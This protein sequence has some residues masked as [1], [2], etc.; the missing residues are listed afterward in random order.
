MS[1]PKLLQPLSRK[2]AVLHASITLCFSSKLSL[3]VLKRPRASHATVCRT[4]PLQSLAAVASVLLLMPSITSAKGVLSTNTIF[5]RYVVTDS[6]A[7]LRYALPLPSERSGVEPVPI[8]QVQEQL[9]RLGVDLRARGA[10][11]LISGRRDLARLRD[12]LTTSRL[13]VLL[14]VPAKKRQQAAELLSK[15]EACLNEIE[16]ELGTSPS[17]SVPAMFPPQLM[18]IQ[19]T[20]S[21]VMERRNNASKKFNYDGKWSVERSF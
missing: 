18:R 1:E 5:R 3:P 14:D 19:E 2:N 9:E 4:A 7:I 21:D 17:S 15:L 12:L 20:V 11:G 8:R 10:A 6:D 13:D 16:D